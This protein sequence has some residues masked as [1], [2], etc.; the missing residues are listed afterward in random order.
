[1]LFRKAIKQKYRGQDHEQLLQ[2]KAEDT[3]TIKKMQEQQLAYL[4]QLGFLEQEV[5]VISSSAIH[6]Y[7][8]LYQELLNL[9]FIYV[10]RRQVRRGDS[11]LSIFINS[12]IY[13]MQDHGKTLTQK[14]NKF[15]GKY[16]HTKEWQE[17]LN[18][19]KLAELLLIA[20]LVDV[21]CRYVE[22]CLNDRGY[23]SKLFNLVPLN[24]DEL[25]FKI[26]T[27][28]YEQLI[29]GWATI[30]CKL[31]VNQELDLSVILVQASD[32]AHQNIMSDSPYQATAMHLNEQAKTILERSKNPLIA[33]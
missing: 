8:A 18:K 19:G 33:Q 25:H 2:L 15:I 22:S 30:D 5:A 16:F 12:K 26:A 9:R 10:D 29:N 13:A 14:L 20:E 31:G 24:E 7:L 6:E 1:M 11:L 3:E 28:V 17:Y 27:E 23:T 4:E 32:L 21:A